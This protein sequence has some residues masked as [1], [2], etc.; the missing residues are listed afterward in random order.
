MSLQFTGDRPRGEEAGRQEARVGSD[1]NRS[2]LRRD[3]PRRP[4]CNDPERTARNTPSACS[5]VPKVAGKKRL[6]EAVVEFVKVDEASETELER[7]EHLNVLIKEKH[8]P[9]ANL[10]LFRPWTSRVESSGGIAPQV[11]GLRPY[12]SMATFSCS[13][14]VR[15]GEAQSDPASILRV[16]LGS[17][18]L[19][20]HN[21]MD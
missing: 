8:I 18:R 5:L 7:L 20:V 15:C 16:R 17:Q 9:I 14:S 13:A 11:Y 2:R 6:A 12:G 3:L 1:E 4:S 10:D 19:F 21:S